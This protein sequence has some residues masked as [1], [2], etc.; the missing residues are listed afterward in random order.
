[1]TI[2]TSGKWWRGTV[3]EDLDEYL[4][5][6]T[7]QDGGHPL[8]VFRPSQCLC[9][10]RTFLVS[11]DKNE[12]AAERT[13]TECQGRHLIADSAESWDDARPRKWRC[14]CKSDKCNV[15][16]GFALREGGGDVRWI[17]VGVRCLSC[18]V[19]GCLVDWSI[20]YGPSLHLL[21]LA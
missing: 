13:C 20:D 5:R 9:G 6:L 14:V 16:V 15:V 1:M 8:D 3:P 7:S 19:L 11:A 10:G 4:R 2:D 21:D 17:Y 12:G 18:G